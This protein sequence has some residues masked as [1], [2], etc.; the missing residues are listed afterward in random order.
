MTYRFRFTRKA[1]KGIEELTP[2]LRDK[3]KDILRHRLAVDP[4]SGKAL[5][6]YLKGCYSVRLGFKGRVVSL[7][8]DEDLVVLVLRARTR[9]VK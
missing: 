6:G 8:H 1:A 4:Y 5:A 7:I 3:F 2:K 9:Y